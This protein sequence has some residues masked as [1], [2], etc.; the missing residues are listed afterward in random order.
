M[1]FITKLLHHNLVPTF[2]QVQ[3]QFVNTEDKARAEVPV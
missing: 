1:A 3:G 2:A